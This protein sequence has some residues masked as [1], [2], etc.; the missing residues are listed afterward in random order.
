MTTGTAPAQGTP[1]A[2]APVL[3]RGPAE[4]LLTEHPAPDDE[5][6]HPAR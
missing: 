6:R 4:D 1:S 3:L 2:D 5:G